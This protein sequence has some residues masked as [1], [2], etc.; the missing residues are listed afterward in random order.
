MSTRLT[1]AIQEHYEKLAPSER[2]LATLLVD[3]ADDLLAYS[4]S[5]MAAM[6]GVSKATAARLFRSLGYAD[7]NEVK[8]QARQERNLA[9][10]F[11]REVESLPPPPRGAPTVAQHLHAEIDSLTR[12]F[13]TLRGDTL[14]EAA[15]L[16]AAA[17]R[18][19]RRGVGLDEG[20]VRFLRPQLARVRPEVFL[21]EP[22]GGLW[23]ESLALT[24]AR[25]CLLLV[26][27]QPRVTLLDAVLTHAAA[28]RM[29]IVAVVDIRNVAWARRSAQ[30]VL[31][32][33]GASAEHA[34]SAMAGAS[35]LHLLVQHV[36]ERLGERARQRQ[37][38]VRAIRRELDEGA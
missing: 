37:A 13:E 9:P 19:W 12:T 23:A 21:L 34:Y 7:F 4:A 18:V 6:A 16:V 32:V 17:P 2:R 38:G 14:R 25:D 28:T 26:Q 27:T 30:S 8:L 22:P 35:M 3:R 5:E 20:L 1:L 10:P 31:P 11:Q 15:A 33:I 29:S 36:A 24:S